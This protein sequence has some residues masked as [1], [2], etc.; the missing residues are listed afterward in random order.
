[1]TLRL[2]MCVGEEQDWEN[3][4]IDAYL[5]TVK[6]VPTKGQ[7]SKEVAGPQQLSTA[8]QNLK[9][10]E[11]VLK[12]LCTSLKVSAF[13]APLPIGHQWCLPPTLISDSGVDNIMLSP[14][15]KV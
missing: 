15:N 12:N 6:T 10:L 11:G 5:V 8:R 7:C 3:I 4:P 2:V 14:S 9:V 1:M 13:A